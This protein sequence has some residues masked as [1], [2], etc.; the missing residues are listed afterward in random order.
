MDNAENNTT[1]MKSF[2]GLL[3]KCDL[4]TFDT[5]EHQFFCFPHT[6]NICTGHIVSSLNSSPINRKPN[7]NHIVPREQMYSQALAHDPIAMAWAAIQ[8]IRVSSAHRDAFTAVI[9]DG[10]M[11][12]WFKN[13]DTGVIMRISPL[14]LL[15]DV[16]SRWDSVYYMIG[17][18]W[19]L[20]LVSG[21]IN[22]TFCMTNLYRQA[23]NNLLAQLHLPELAKY[24]L[25]EKEWEVLRD[26]EVILSVIIVIT[27]HL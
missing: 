4:D 22:L 25:S 6:T 20:H 8:A 17:R 7:E 9:R 3:H 16:P 10:N 26:F 21:S 5:K 15:W 1:M 18:F 12:G 19:Y 2:E 27:S 13:P 14:Q 23:V 24:R 11:D